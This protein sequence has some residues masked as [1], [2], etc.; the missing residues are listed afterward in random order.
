M[1]KHIDLGVDMRA[2]R[3]IKDALINYRNAVQ[4][5]NVSSLETVVDHLLDSATQ[6]AE[7]AQRAAAAAL[8]QVPD[9]DS[10]GSPE[11]L[12]LSYVSGEKM[13]DRT[14]RALVTPWFKF[15]WETYRTVLDVLKNNSRLEGLYAD[16]AARAANFCLTHQRATE[17][18]RL[19]DMLRNHLSNLL[20]YRDQGGANRTDLAEPATWERYA[21]MR[22]E[23]LRT[24]CALGLWAEAFRCVEDV[25]GL[26]AAAP[27]ASHRARAA[28]MSPFYA[29]LTRIFARSESRLYNAYAWYR[30]FTFSRTQVKGLPAGDVATLASNVVLSAL[31][32]MP[33]EV[34]GDPERV[35]EGIARR[36]HQG[37][38]GK[39]AWACAQWTAVLS[40]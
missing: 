7:G 16:A 18:R 35:L 1:L 11:E 32:I 33:Y 24:A 12:M 17:F 21:G 36:V 15:L 31:A 6:R 13:A 19:C 5:L 26:F 38:A 34:S 30:L 14:D 37:R 39:S 20:R 25:Q 29:A 4:A 23:Q 28:L 10:A 9:L 40:G 3:R 22:F 27:R 2:G 8:E